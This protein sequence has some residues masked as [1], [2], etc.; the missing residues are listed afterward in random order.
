[1]HSRPTRVLRGTHGFGFVA[2]PS[3]HSV[4]VASLCVPSVPTCFVLIFAPS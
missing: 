3:S 2:V 4:S 1:L